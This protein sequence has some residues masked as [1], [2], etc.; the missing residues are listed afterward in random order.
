MSRPAHHGAWP[1]MLTPFTTRDEVDFETVDRYVDWLIDE[2]STGL[3]PVALSGEMFQLSEPER[4]AVAARVVRRA[5]GRVPVAA[6]IA[7]HGTP[8]ATA[9]AASRL[10]EAGV[11]VVVLIASVVLHEGDDESVF[12]EVARAVL[13]ANPG[14]TFGVYE[15]PLPYHRLLSDELLEWIAAT[16]RFSFL[17]ETS[18]DTAVMATRVR[19]GSSAGLQIF[20][21]GIEDHVDSLA[22]GVAGLSGWVVNVAPD[23][24]A[25]L[26]DIVARDGATA[27]ARELQD[28]LAQ[29]EDRM[30]PTYPGSAKAIVEA[31]AGVG[32]TTRSRWRPSD[33]DVAD[34]RAI[35]ELLDAAAQAA[36]SGARS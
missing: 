4:L 24:V 10:A 32:F 9:E 29:V 2:G 12:V 36:R 27:R 26:G 16:G 1:V 21:A 31:R 19:I 25:E 6:A 28:L 3:F 14:V 20:N 11:D 30:G 22:V 23:L 7:E 33:V 15:C 5:A 34:A 18:H 35:A 8:A 17:K 13:D